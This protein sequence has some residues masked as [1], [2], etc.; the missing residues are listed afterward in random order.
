MNYILNLCMPLVMSGVDTV[1][2]SLMTQIHITFFFR[3][4]E[5]KWV[6]SIE[7]LYNMTFML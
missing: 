4:H 2:L 5:M 1:L 3:T 7:W 6:D